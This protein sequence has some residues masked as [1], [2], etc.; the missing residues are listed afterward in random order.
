MT[1]T[2]GFRDMFLKKTPRKKTKGWEI[3]LR[4]RSELSKWE[5]SKEYDDVMK[6]IGKNRKILLSTFKDMADQG[7][8]I[9]P[10]I[11]KQTISQIFITNGLQVN[12]EFWPYLL[13]FA[14]KDG[15]V[16]YRFMLDVYRDRINA[17]NSHPK[18]RVDLIKQ[19]S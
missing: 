9:T 17:L 13:R 10:D 7:K 4:N 15:V 8:V 12:D 11:V 6:C 18:V 16:D 19:E 14:E 5:C 3:N 2:T 1:V